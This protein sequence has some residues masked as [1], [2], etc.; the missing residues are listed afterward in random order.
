MH[1]YYIVNLLVH[2]VHCVL[3]QSTCDKSTS[4]MWLTSSYMMTVPS[5][6]ML[7]LSL[8][9][10][11]CISIISSVNTFQGH[12]AIYLSN[13]GINYLNLMTLFKYCTRLLLI[14]IIVSMVDFISANKNVTEE[15]HKFQWTSRVSSYGLGIIPPSFINGTLLIDENAKKE[16]VSICLILY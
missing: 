3:D 14:L 7:A 13:T 1:Y 5:L 6:I 12:I 2:P 9:I 10:Y 4:S 11:R 15:T 16:M 8:Y